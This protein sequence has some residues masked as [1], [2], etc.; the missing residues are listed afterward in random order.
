RNRFACASGM[1]RAAGGGAVNENMPL[2]RLSKDKK[3]V[4]CARIDCG[5]VFAERWAY[6]QMAPSVMFGSGWVQHEGTWQMSKRARRRLSEGRPPAFRRDPG[7]VGGG[8]KDAK[9][10]HDVIQGR[11]FPRNRRNRP[12]RFFLRHARLPTDVDCPACGLRQ[13]AE[14]VSLR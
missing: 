4:I 3:A 2:A 12:E 5:E 14:P 13:L 10:G 6:P 8:W 1:D 9:H 11:P 7:F